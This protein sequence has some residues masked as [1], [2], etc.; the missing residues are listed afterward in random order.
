MSLPVEITRLVAL[1]QETLHMARDGQGETRSA[2]EYENILVNIDI[3]LAMTENNKESE[4]IR[5]VLEEARIVAE[6]SLRQLRSGVLEA[7][8]E[9]HH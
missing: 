2:A 6:C 3:A 8:Q 4:G 5:F 1:I 7:R 9:V